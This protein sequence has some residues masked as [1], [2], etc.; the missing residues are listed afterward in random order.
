MKN[1]L[2]SIPILLLVVMTYAGRAQSRLFFS[3]GVVDRPANETKI[4]SYVTTL[5]KNVTCLQIVSGIYAYYGLAGDKLFTLDCPTEPVVV[6]P[7]IK[8]FPNPATNYIRVQSNQLLID[9]PSLPLKIIDATGRTVMQKTVSNN[10]LY[11]GQSLF[12]GMLASGNY[13]LIIESTSLKQI[14][15]FIKVN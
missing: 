2:Y 3:M 5:D 1:I 14:I 15:P 12:V 8:L 11:A 6:R 4:A 9:H 7:E 10:Q 13:F